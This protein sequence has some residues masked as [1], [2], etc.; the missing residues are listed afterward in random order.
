VDKETGR[1]ITQPIGDLAVLHER[2]LTLLTRIAPPAYLHSAVK[3]RS[4]ATKVLS[5]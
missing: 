4:Y 1:L 2:I 3:K 5:Q